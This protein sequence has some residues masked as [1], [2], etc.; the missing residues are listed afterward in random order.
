MVC[1]KIIALGGSISITAMGLFLMAPPVSAAPI[2][3]AA[4]EVVARHVTYADL[5]LTSLPGERTLNRRVGAAVNSL[6]AEAVGEADGSF[7]VKYAALGC[8]NSAWNQARP[9]INRAVQR[10]RDLAST[11][12]SN[13]AAVTIMVAA[14]D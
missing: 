8:H 1:S 7:T 9:Q 10:A 11:G 2:I 6:C 14:P 5:N 3:V 12:T 13:I 4:P